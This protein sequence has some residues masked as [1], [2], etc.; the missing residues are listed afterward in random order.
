MDKSEYKD[1][2]EYE[3]CQGTC[4]QHFGNYRAFAGHA[5]VLDPTRYMVDIYTARAFDLKASHAVERMNG[6]VVGGYGVPLDGSILRELAYT[7][8]K[9]EEGRLNVNLANPNANDEENNHIFTLHRLVMIVA[10]GKG[11]SIFADGALEGVDVHPPTGSTYDDI[12]AYHPLTSTNE[13]TSILRAL[14]VGNVH[15]KQSDGDHRMGKDMRYLNG[16]LFCA[17]TSHRMNTCFSYARKNMGHWGCGCLIMEYNG[18]V[19]SA[20]HFY[21]IPAVDEIT[22]P[23]VEDVRA[24]RSFDNDSLP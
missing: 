22:F 4:F 21:V 3:I 18:G 23:S 13:K 10:N 11:I 8:S 12:I 6:E 16:L 2:L 20:A 7:P 17:L 15:S 24:G 1:E 9:S 5:K 14:R 19:E